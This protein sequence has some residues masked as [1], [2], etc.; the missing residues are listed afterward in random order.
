MKKERY[1]GNSRRRTTRII[2]L[3]FLSVVLVGTLLLCLPISSNKG[4]FTN[5]LDAAFTA[6]SATCVTGLVTLDTATHWSLFGQ[7]VILVMIQIGGLGFMTVAVQLSLLIK[8]A[9]TPKERMLVAMSYNIDS[10]DKTG[11]LMRRIWIGTLCI[12]VV[13]AAVLST[14]F[15]PLFGVGDGIY[16]SIFH[17]ISAFCNA[18]FDIFGA[19]SGEF[20]SVAYFAEDPVVNI[21]LMFLIVMGGIGFIV[22]ND[23]VNFIVRKK[24]ISVYS[25]FV[26][27]ITVILIFGGAVVFALLEWNNP[28]TIGNMSVGNKIMASTFQSVTLRTAGFAAIDQ[29]GLMQ[30]SQLISVILMFIGGASGSTAGGVKVGT[31][32]V[33]ICTIW[34][35]AIGKKDAVIFKRR[36]SSA[37]F[38]RAVTIVSI[39]LCLV[40][41]G[42]MVVAESMG[43]S[44]MTALF[45]AASASGTVGIS[46]GITPELN[47][48]SKLVIMTLMFLGRVGILTV[49]YGVM[50][51][52]SESYST[53]SYPDANMLIG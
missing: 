39:Q 15:I 12:E 9:V 50:V 38:M 33:I 8:R 18:G 40:F 44:V 5:P 45:E 24:R 20:R 34:A 53:I 14:R 31:I 26:M 30:P 36:I 43:C 6:V 37:S 27:I 3:G 13:G 47:I 28:E 32:G 16:K 49:T 2:I 10:Y 17:A 7:I 22:W 41:I 29:A 25:K 23:I 21:T 19:F 1:H 51:N 46:L 35:T 48:I 52:L 4:G 42:T 11:E